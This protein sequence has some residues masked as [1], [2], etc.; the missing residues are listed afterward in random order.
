MF[1]SEYSFH[2][3]CLKVNILSMK[4]EISMKKVSTSFGK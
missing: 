2:E 4:S 1:E 3:K